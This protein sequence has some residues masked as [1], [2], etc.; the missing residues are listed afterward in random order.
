M[1][2]TSPVEAVVGEEA[3]EAGDPDREDV[4]PLGLVAPGEERHRGRVLGLP[5]RLGRGHLHR[6]DADHVLRLGVAD[7][8]DRDAWPTK[9]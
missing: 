3:Q 8:H 2:L 7:H 1:P 9:A 6:L 4:L 5:E